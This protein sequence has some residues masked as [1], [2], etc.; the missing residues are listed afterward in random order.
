[1]P[2][3]WRTAKCAWCG[4]EWQTRS[5]TARTCNPTCRARLREQEHGPTKGSPPRK[6][7][8]EVVDK[9]RSLYESGH[10]IAEVQAAVSGVKVQLIMER[11][12]VE[13]RAA[14]K[15][16]QSGDRNH[17]WAGDDAGYTALHLRV[18]AKRGAPQ[19]CTRCGTDAASRYEW[20][21]LTGNYQDVND[22][23][24]MCVACHR[25]FDAARRRATGMRTSPAR[26]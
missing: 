8:A 9:V 3:P 13:R 14:A 18:Y 20:A 6:Y 26:R 24:R 21:N 16:N 5:L 25:Q 19:S 7:P 17:M 12:G 10:T 23:Q 2:S 1:M 15:R 11:Y 4:N 22:Y